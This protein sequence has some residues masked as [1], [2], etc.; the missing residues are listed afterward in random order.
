LLKP[1]LV[2]GLPPERAAT[3]HPSVVRAAILLVQEAGGIAMVGDSPGMGTLSTVMRG[4]KYQEILEATG[5]R[6][7]DFSEGHNFEAP[8]NKIARRMILTKALLEADV[9]ITL[10]KLKTHAQMTM[11]GALKNQ[12]GLIPGSMKSQWHFRLQRPEWLASLILDIN[13]IAKPS[14]AIMDAITTMEGEGPTSGTPR[15]LGALLASSDLA[16][17]DTLAC[18]LIGLDP[19]SVPVLR[20]AL[21][22]SFGTTD[23][24]NLQIR[25]D[26]WQSLAVPDFKKIQHTVD[27]TRL[28]PL[29]QPVLAWI[30]RQWS[31]LPRIDKTLCTGCG[32]CEK[33]CPVSPSAIHPDHDTASVDVN[34]CIQC[35]CCHEF[36]PSK[37]IQLRQ[38]WL[39]RYLPLHAMAN[40][41]SQMLGALV[42][43]K[44]Q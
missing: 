6:L 15:F 28:L 37:A 43:R 18:Q 31:S 13:R 11:T 1:N 25:G 4:G 30:G 2:L 32:F 16:A 24:R 40:R 21:E 26:D 34:R 3:T 44:H 19:M 14:L 39:A 7:T 22:Q 5:A 36:C 23:I 10:P 12:F 17:V 9:V 20:A 8:D 42:A 41:A 33:G 29:P 35:Y 38:T 27:L